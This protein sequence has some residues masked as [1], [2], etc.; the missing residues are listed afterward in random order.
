MKKNN[1]NINKLSRQNLDTGIYRRRLKG[2]VPYNWHIVYKHSDLF[3]S[4][5]KDLLSK[6]VKQLR[7]F[8]VVIEEVIKT[9]PNFQKSLMPVKENKDYPKIIN[10]MIRKSRNFNVGPMASVA[11][12]VC[13]YI[14]RNL[15]GKCS[16]LLIENG[17]DVFIKSI[18]DLTVGIHVENDNFRNKICLRIKKGQTPCGL[19]SSS[20]I[21]GHSLSLG[22]SDLVTV[23]GKTT[24]GADAAATAL[25]NRV[26]KEKD[27]N[28]AIDAFK[29]KAGIMGMLVIKGKRLGAW[30]NIEL[31]NCN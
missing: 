10:E 7:D 18:K 13:D 2:L 30:G 6:I 23:L 16:T 21:F 29:N 17:G 12:A 15:S 4:C 26:G 5:S 31:V 28:V 1:L 9:S 11:G 19:C 20:G 8:Y 27:I 14:G 25:G 22:K 3:V 24:I